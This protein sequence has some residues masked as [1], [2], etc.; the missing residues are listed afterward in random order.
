MSGM[1]R[2]VLCVV[3]AR[4]LSRG[5]AVLCAAW[6]L[7]QVNSRQCKN[8]CSGRDMC[9]PQRGEAPGA[10]WNAQHQ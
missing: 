2:D 3:S 10:S 6:R 1:L 8:E 4:L 5:V 7:R 9:G